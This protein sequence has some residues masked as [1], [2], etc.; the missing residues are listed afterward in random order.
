MKLGFTALALLAFTS[1]VSAAEI[2]PF[3]N[4]NLNTTQNTVKVKPTYK[5][6]STAMHAQNEDAFLRLIMDSS[7]D[8][9]TAAKN[10]AIYALDFHH[11]FDGNQLYLFARMLLEAKEDYPANVLLKQ[12]IVR[13]TNNSAPEVLIKVADRLK[14]NNPILALKAYLYVQESSQAT[15]AEKAIAESGFND[16]KNDFRL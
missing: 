9:A 3:S 4:I 1:N 13:N 11:L 10:A 5:D 6:C 7:L 15:A 14:Q 2:I 8:Q 16:L 12:I